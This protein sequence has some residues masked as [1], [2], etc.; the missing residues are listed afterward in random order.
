[1]ERKLN[2]KVQ[3]W[4]KTFKDEIMRFIDEI[5]FQKSLK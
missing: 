2:N 3:L 1:M 5:Q 4:C